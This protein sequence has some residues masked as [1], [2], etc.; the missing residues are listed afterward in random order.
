MLNLHFGRAIALRPTLAFV[1]ALLALGGMAQNDITAD[2]DAAFNR[3][4]Y[5]EAAKDY[6]ASYAKLKGDLE[7]KGRVCYCLLYTSPS[8]R[9]ATLSRMPSSA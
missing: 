9:D 1:F 8:P 3:G 2:A 7:E 5:F 4:G 6:Q